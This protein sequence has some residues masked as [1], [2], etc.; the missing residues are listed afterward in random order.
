MSTK[1][2]VHRHTKVLIYQV[3]SIHMLYFI[4]KIVINFSLLDWKL[5][6]P[7]DELNYLSRYSREGVTYYMSSSLLRI[8]WSVKLDSFAVGLNV[9]FSKELT[10]RLIFELYSVQPVTSSIPPH[11]RS[12]TTLSEKESW[13]FEACKNGKNSIKQSGPLEF[14][15]FE[16]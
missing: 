15:R 2:L 11:F 13:H 16:R 14:E 12:V 10:F 3:R 7:G 9:T 6:W 8:F 4:D 5:D 1:H